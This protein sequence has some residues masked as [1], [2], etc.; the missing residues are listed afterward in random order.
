MWN[1]DQKKKKERKK[2]KKEKK[3]KERNRTNKNQQIK[4]KIVAPYPQR[5]LWSILLQPNLVMKQSLVK[6]NCCNREVLHATAVEFCQ[7]WG[8]RRVEANKVTS[9]HLGI[10]RLE[11]STI[12]S[13]ERKSARGGSGRCRKLRLVAS[14]S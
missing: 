4:T 10:E 6:A 11:K 2:R 9:L 1:T 5:D 12:C 13:S 8:A 3:R 14:F 7:G